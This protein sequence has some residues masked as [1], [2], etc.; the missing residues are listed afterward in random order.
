M[1]IQK[2]MKIIGKKL[3]KDI[4]YF[5]LGS[6]LLLF[7]GEM[8][9]GKKRVEK[10]VLEAE[11]KSGISLVSVSPGSFKMGAQPNL[12]CFNRLVEHTGPDWDEAPVHEVRID[13]SFQISSKKVVNALYEEFD[14]KHKSYRGYHEAPSGD[15]DPVVMVTWDDAVA[16][17]EWLTQKEGKPYRL[18]TEAEWEY[19]AKQ[20]ELLGLQDTDNEITEWCYDWWDIYPGK[21]LTNPTGPKSG[22]VKVIR[23]SERATNRWGTVR[24]DR[25]TTLSFRVVQAPFPANGFYEAQKPGKVFQNVKQTKKKWKLV[26]KDKPVFHDAMDFIRADAIP[27]NVP[28]WGRHHVPCITWCDNGDILATAFT[29]ADDHLTQI[30]VLTSRLRD[31][32]NQWDPP[33]LFFIAPDHSVNSAVLWHDSNGELHHYN[34]IS[35]PEKCYNFSVTKR[36]SKDNGVT[37]SEPVIVN[38]RFTSAPF[39]AQVDMVKLSDGRLAFPTDVHNGTILFASNDSGD[40]WEEI[41]RYEWNKEQFA[42]TDGVSGW[43][44][45]IHASFVELKD[46]NFLALGRYSDINGHSPF[47]I[48]NDKGKSWTYEASPFPPIGSWQRSII[49]RLNEGPLLLT[50]FTDL[51]ASYADKTQKGIE[52]IDK[53]GRVQQIYGLFSALSFDEGKT[54]VHRKLIPIKA[55]DPYTSPFG[56]Y[57]SGT[58]TPDNMIHIVSSQFYY[59]FNLAWLMEPVLSPSNQKK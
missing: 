43:I 13:Y 48:S 56:G 26:P 45:G 57:L 42:K 27:G 35:L 1:E 16:F 41:T 54:W 22:Y 23:G 8:A 49:K 2:N 9:V 20:A 46:G 30:A 6:S 10:H 47:S 5:L 58:Q 24:G 33:A 55:S 17:C 15:L 32:A 3:R 19:A 4:C 21:E 31:G 11:N 53:N 34:S 37:W 25:F 18:P 51:G 39:W 36:V 40:S 52:V 50:S 14:P 28:Y 44:A 12:D 59:R 38:E 29:A 7:S